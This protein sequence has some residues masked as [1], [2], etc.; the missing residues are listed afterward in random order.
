MQLHYSDL[1]PFARKVRIVLLEKGLDSQVEKVEVSP[2][3]PGGQLLLANPLSKVPTLVL[4]DGTALYDSAVICDYLDSLTGAPL[5]IPNVG[6][7][8]FVARR[9][10]ALLDGILEASFNISCERNRRPESERSANWVSHWGEAVARG[11]DAL[12]TE[13]R[14]FGETL[15]LVHISAV[16]ALDYVSFR[17]PDLIDWRSHHSGLCGWYEEF[18]E[19][20]AMRATRPGI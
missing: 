17:A 6:M 10:L 15:S 8:H 9:R 18:G 1:S 2:Y 14:S 3:E 19:R 13:H 7:P 11:V 12:E 5:G 20:E 4:D 16:C